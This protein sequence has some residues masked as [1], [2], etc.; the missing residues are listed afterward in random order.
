ME[1]LLAVTAA[2][3]AA[4]WLARTLLRRMAAP[5]CGPADTPAGAD[6]FVPLERLTPVTKKPGRP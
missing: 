5:P 6:G 2:V 3:A 4:L 1:D